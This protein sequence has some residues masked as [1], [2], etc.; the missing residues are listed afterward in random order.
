M[1]DAVGSIPSLT[2]RGVPRSSLRRSSSSEITS[3]AFAVSRR[4]WRSTSTMGDGNKPAVQGT[5][6]SCLGLRQLPTAAH[7]GR[8][9]WIPCSILSPP[10]RGGVR[11]LPGRHDRS[12]ASQVS[13][14]WSSS[15]G[16][17]P[18]RPST[19]P[20]RRARRARRAARHLR[21]PQPRRPRPWAA[22]R[23][24]RR[25][26]VSYRAK[27]RRRVM[28]AE[29]RFH[30]MGSDVHVLV[31]GG[32]PA[33]VTHAR[34]RIAQLEQRWSRFRTDSEV[35][36]LNRRAGETMRV[37]PDTMLLVQR[38]LDAIHLTGGLFDPTVLGAVIRAGY[39]RSFD[40]TVSFDRGG[41]SNLTRGT[42]AI[43]GDAVRLPAGTG[44]DP[45]GL[46]KGLAADLVVRELLDG[47][48]DGT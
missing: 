28:P 12:P 27:P 31:V 2:R 30:A 34:R 46:G 1:S 4:S 22:T 8:Q 37:S 7:V 23:R 15:L 16:A 38:A 45:G 39:N 17:W 20:P 42:L 47:G 44:F 21:R 35:S 26:P 33:L 24:R 3:T 5:A 18:P 41:E 48:A 11:T 6:S 9:R 14:A 40:P 19:R 32:S 10:P 43:D 25:R 29:L 36:E 13:P